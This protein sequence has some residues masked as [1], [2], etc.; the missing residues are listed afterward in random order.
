[1]AAIAT[2]TTRE[3]SSGSCTLRVTGQLSPLGQVA[4]KPV[5]VRSRFHL[6]LW[7]RGG[8]QGSAPRLELSGLAHQLSSLT[9]SVGDYVQG[10]LTLADPGL[11]V[12]DR[13]PK[14][15]VLQPLGLTR[16]RLTLP[17]DG[18]AN[19][20]REV[21][22]SALELA[23]LADVLEQAEAELYLPTEAEWPGVKS[24]RPR[25]PVWIGSAAAVGIAAILGSQWLPLTTP[26]TNPPTASREGNV[27]PE[28]HQA[29]E[30]PSPGPTPDLEGSPT[31]PAYPAAADAHTE[32]PEPLP[33]PRG[34]TGQPAVTPETAGSSTLSAE[35]SA[36]PDVPT[37]PLPSA[38][39]DGPAVA[40]TPV[41]MATP[42]PDTV[43]PPDAAPPEEAQSPTAPRTAPAPVSPAPAPSSTQEEGLDAA[44]PLADPRPVP[45]SLRLPETV[46]PTTTTGVTPEAPTADP[47]ADSAAVAL[48][49]SEQ[50]R[51]QLQQSWTPAPNQS[52]PLHYRLS[53][54]PNG[55]LQGIT[56]LSDQAQ[57]YQDQ[58]PWP[59]I[60]TTVA[61]F[62]GGRATDL[63]L[64]F[65]PSGEV[66]IVLLHLT[67]GESG[68]D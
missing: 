66:N 54:A 39:S 44:E 33:S 29:L 40:R 16:H 50:L 47:L 19:Q 23:D 6:Q 45:E 67:P 30:S 63:E 26:L 57:Q 37:P 9:T 22:L 13:P 43:P 18:A 1:M 7:P 61:Q 12:P 46:S 25:L 42:S 20:G 21:D 17:P 34:A 55:V 52:L 8:I 41:P 14:G 49:W 48:P 58:I 15:I 27:A 24:S 65:L 11:A 38:S 64:Q 36:E 3:Y 2:L 59:E 68:Q 35:L 5:L 32:P 4:A 60:G 51:L 31:G 56:A 62:P 28:E 53:I 10:Q